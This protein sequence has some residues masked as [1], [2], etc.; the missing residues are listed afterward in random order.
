MRLKYI[1]GTLFIFL[2]AIGHSQDRLE[3]TM[4]TTAQVYAKNNAYLEF[5]GKGLFYSFNYERRLFNL[6]EKTSVNG[7]IGFS[8][9]PGLTQVKGSTDFL[10]PLSISIQQ[11]LKKNHH[12]VI[13]TGSTYYSYQ[14]NDIEISNANLISQPLRA[15]LKTV[16]EWFGHLNF[17]YRHQKPEGG[18]MFKAGIT[19]LFFDRMQN[20]EGMKTAQFSANAGIG[21]GF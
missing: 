17:E 21:F 6:G 16:T 7:S 1:L 4:D 18:F 20:F 15:R 9:F 3:G 19:P 5:G 8:L 14:I 13:G 11:H 10:M 2:L 12:L